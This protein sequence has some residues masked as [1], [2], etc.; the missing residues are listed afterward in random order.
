MAMSFLYN[1]VV[2]V[3]HYE[4]LFL[5]QNLGLMAECSLWNSICDSIEERAPAPLCWILHAYV[6]LMVVDITN[7]LLW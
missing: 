1:K 6:H 5:L 4:Y 7:R 3:L 2:N